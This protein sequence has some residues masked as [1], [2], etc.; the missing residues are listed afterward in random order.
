[1]KDRM[2]WVSFSMLVLMSAAK[3]TMAAAVE[4]PTSQQ[5]QTLNSQIQVQL[6]GMHAQIQ[7]QMQKMNQQLQAQLKDVQMQ[8]QQQMQKMNQQLQ[9]Q[10][11]QVQATLQQE[12]DAVNTTLGKSSTAAPTPATS[13]VP[14]KP[15][16]AKPVLKQP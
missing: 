7:Q 10:M 16:A 15:A 3:A 6:E 9:T 14:A 5:I 2:V 8:Q 12:I 13:T 1:M 11:K 4:A